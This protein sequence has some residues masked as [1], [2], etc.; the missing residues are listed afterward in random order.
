VLRRVWSGPSL[1]QS[2]VGPIDNFSVLRL[3]LAAAVVVSH[4]YSIPTGNSTLEPL[5]HATG[6][7][8]GEHAVNFFFAISG[9]L[10]TM[11]FLNR[12]PRDYAVAR[13]LRI[14]PAFVVAALVTVF[15]IGLAFT[16]LPPGA[17]LTDPALYKYLW[18]VLTGFKSAGQMP[19]VFA[20]NPHPWPLGTIWTLRYEIGLYAAVL[21][22]GIAGALRSAKVVG[23][24][25]ALLL[26][27]LV[28]LEAFV[29]Q[30]TRYVEVMLRL[31][32]LFA[33]G[34]FFYLA[35]AWVRL[36]WLLAVV[37]AGLAW[38]TFDT[39]FYFSFLY[40]AEAYGIFVIAFAVRLPFVDLTDRADL[41]YG[42]YLYGYPVQQGLVALF[43][44]AAP[45]ALLMPA[46]AISAVFAWASWRLVEEPA[47]RLKQLWA[48]K[49]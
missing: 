11:S 47:L 15:G 49:G 32:T 42:I 40:L 12:G 5:Y 17:Y 4:G 29:P 14:V 44:H 22:F 6:L 45:V 36:S 41:S 3:V 18:Q 28:V 46:L 21:L 25:A 1:A 33:L 16:T 24:A 8:L 43:P 31:I 27:A 20:D 48:S 34:S 23:G 19:G 26:L 37:L 9:F 38:I 10:V 7:R 35:R 2:M 39:P 13:A 30:T